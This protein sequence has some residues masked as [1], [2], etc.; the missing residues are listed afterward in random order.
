VPCERL[1]SGSKQTATDRRARLGADRFEQF[2]IM[3]S[4]WRK[5]LVDLAACNSAEVEEVDLAEF[6][7]MLREDVDASEWDFLVGALPSIG[8]DDDDS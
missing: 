5:D 6:E 4:A 7:D 3:K 2:Q 1:F 8:I